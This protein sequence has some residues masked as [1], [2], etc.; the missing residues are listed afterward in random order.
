MLHVKV[1]PLGMLL[2]FKIFK[3]QGINLELPLHGV[4]MVAAV[5]VNADKLRIQECGGGADC[6]P[7]RLPPL[8]YHRKAHS[9]PP[10]A[11]HHT[12][13]LCGC[14][15]LRVQQSVCFVVQLHSSC[16]RA[17]ELSSWVQ[18]NGGSKNY[19]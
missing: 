5:C 18:S 9:R 7:T 2:A 13:L 16:V 3:Y 11:N 1:K 12:T 17:R 14:H 6:Q 10:Q 4:R 15:N 8:R 19:Y